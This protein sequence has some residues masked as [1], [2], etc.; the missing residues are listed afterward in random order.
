MSE[1]DITATG[2]TVDKPFPHLVF[3]EDTLLTRA[4]ADQL[5]ATFPHWSALTSSTRTQGSD[6][7]YSMN[8]LLLHDRGRWL[9]RLEQLPDCWSNLLSGL[10]ESSYRDWLVSRLCGTHD[11][12][13]LEVRLSE[14][15]RGGW[16][17]RHTDRPDKVF[18]QNIYLCPEWQPTWG[19]ELR[20]YHH[21]TAAHPQATY[22]PG[23]GTSVAF[24]RSDRSW[25]EV[26]A[27]SDTAA[28]PR[29]ALL[30]HGYRSTM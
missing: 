14:Y 20:L 4:E 7:S 5:T 21:E 3:A 13:E 29:R 27:V 19:G 12:V 25:H 15:P 6:K 18:S 22:R 17:S 16:M 1:L 24:M 2:T 10:V 30:L 26:A 11:R 8:T 23:A 9:V 28:A